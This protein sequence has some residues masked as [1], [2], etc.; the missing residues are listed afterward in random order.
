[1][2]RNSNIFV[3]ENASENNVCEMAAIFEEE[4][5]WH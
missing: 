4:M 2:N 5:S 1:M 3:H